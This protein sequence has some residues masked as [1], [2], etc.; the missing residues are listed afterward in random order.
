M[1]LR[2]AVFDSCL[3]HEALGAIS[4]ASKINP[5]HAKRLEA[6]D[7]NRQNFRIGLNFRRTV[8][9]IEEWGGAAARLGRAK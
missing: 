7:S 4:S 3:P 5:K 2:L 8:R 1:L 9:R 6:I